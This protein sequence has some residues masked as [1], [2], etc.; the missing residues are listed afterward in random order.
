[1]KPFDN[2][3]VWTAILVLGLWLSGH[4]LTLWWLIPVGVVVGSARLAIQERMA[5]RAPREPNPNARL[6]NHRPQQVPDDE[7]GYYPDEEFYGR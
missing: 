3:I 6:K 5:N 1:M 7:D 4:L 2:P